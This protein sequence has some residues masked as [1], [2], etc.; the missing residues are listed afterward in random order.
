MRLALWLA[1]DTGMTQT[2]SIM[3]SSLVSTGQCMTKKESFLTKT[4]DESNMK[5]M[6]I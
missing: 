4:Q 2:G 5:D 3:T 1:W 6:Q